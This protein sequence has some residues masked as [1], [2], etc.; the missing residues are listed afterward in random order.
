MIP[1]LVL[2][3]CSMSY[4][5]WLKK[6]IFVKVISNKF[7]SFCSI[8]TGHVDIHEY[9][10]VH[11]VWL[12]SL[13]SFNFLNSLLTRE[14]CITL[15]SEACLDHH[16]K[17]LNIEGSIINN[18]DIRLEIYLGLHSPLCLLNQLRIFSLCLNE[19]WLSSRISKI[20]RRNS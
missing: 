16:L 11:F 14:S 6:P 5:E 3:D 18:Q 13:T 12:T 19:M 1:E 15:Y 4:N 2:G 20:K 17:N 9:Q 10:F 7:G 8:N